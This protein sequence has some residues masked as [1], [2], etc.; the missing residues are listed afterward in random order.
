[1][2]VACNVYDGMLRDRFQCAE[3]DG[4][5][6]R[7]TDRTPEIR[8]LTAAVPGVC[9]KTVKPTKKEKTPRFC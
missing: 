9:N 6:P 4:E 7:V 8:C 5:M 3:R 2:R 1:M